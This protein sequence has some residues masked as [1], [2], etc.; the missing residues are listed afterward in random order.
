MNFFEHQDKAKQNTLYLLF[1]FVVA[2]I[3]MIAILYGVVIFAVYEQFIWQ[4]EIMVMVAIG[5]IAVVSGGSIYKSLLLRGGGEVIAE[6]LGGTLVEPGTG[7]EQ[8]QRLLNIVEEMAI[9]SGISVPSVYVLQSERGINAFAAGFNPN[10][11]VIGVTRGCLEQLDRDELQGVIAHEFSHIINGDMRLNLQLIGVLQGLIFIYILGRI[12]LR[13]SFWRGYSSN[14]GKNPGFI[15]GLGMI[16]VG[17]VGFFFGRLI[18]SAIARQR[19]FLADASAVQ[20]TRNPDGI[21]GAL[22]KIAGYKPGSKMIT[23]QAEEASHLFFGEAFTGFFESFGQAF[24]T[25]PPLEERVKRIEGFAGRLA[26]K[27]KAKTPRASVSG[28]EMGNA[29]GNAMVAGFAQSSSP[30]QSL[31]V[32]PDKVVAKVGTTSPK[33]LDQVQGFLADIPEP[34]RMATRDFYGAMA[35]I[36]SLLLHSEQ[37]I[38]DRQMSLLRESESAEV[39]EMMENLH[40][41][42]HSLNARNRLPLIDLAIPALRSGSPKKCQHLLKQVKVLIQVDNHL[43]LSEYAIFLVLRQRLN[44]Y[45]FGKKQEPKTEFNNIKQIWSDC[46]ILLSA[47]AQVGQDSPEASTI[48]FQAGLLRL[49]KNHGQ[50]VPNKPV[51]YSLT[52]VGKTLKRLELATPKLKQAVVDACAYTVLADNNVTLEQGELLRAIVISLNCPIPPFLNAPSKG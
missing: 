9:A 28:N 10:E 49:P 39:L 30:P 32:S 31:S 19:E 6:S 1:L 40:P 29:M 41:Y 42:L 3:C 23:P 24:A 20:F 48:A 16:L 2:I 5:V 46:V 8:E 17:A 43:S 27:W 37:Q 12:L 35:I 50:T 11:A 21:S 18:K 51:A 13:G 4:P 34:V 44:N 47:L 33:H 38:S 15:I 26:A 36:Y 7:D 14:K 52:Q 25:H 22:Q 45:F